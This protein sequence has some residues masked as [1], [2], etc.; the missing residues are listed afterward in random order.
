MCNWLLV[1]AR[2]SVYDSRSYKLRIELPDGILY[3]LKSRVKHRL[4]AHIIG[5]IE[6]LRFNWCIHLLK[7]YIVCSNMTY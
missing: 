5:E 1:F 3:I 6:M 2:K 4:H 7:C